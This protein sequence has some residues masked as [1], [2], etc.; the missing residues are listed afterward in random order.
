MY[1]V[2]TDGTPLITSAG[3]TAVFTSLK[4]EDSALEHLNLRY[5][6]V[7]ERDRSAL[8]DALSRN[9]SLKMPN[10]SPNK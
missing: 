5:S 9:P 6:S 7:K 1:G 3:W 4:N 2:S 10:L 8:T